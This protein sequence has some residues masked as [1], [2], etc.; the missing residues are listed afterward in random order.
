MAMET[1]L[2]KNMYYRLLWR[3]FYSV[4]VLVRVTIAVLK[5]HIQS[6]LERKRVYLAYTSTSQFIIKQSQDRI[7]NRAGTLLETRSDSETMWS[8]HLSFDFSDLL[9]LL[10]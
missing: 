9:S 6:N 5:H 1:G 4:P 7:K 3:I 8:C 2:L 10:S